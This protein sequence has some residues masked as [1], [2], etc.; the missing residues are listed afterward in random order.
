MRH[1]HRVEHRVPDRLAT[2]PLISQ[3]EVR[4]ACSQRLGDNS[5]LGRDV[6]SEL[7]AIRYHRA[8]RSVERI[9]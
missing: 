3:F 9:A 5:M 6:A 4:A 1:A 7:P 2:E 8:R